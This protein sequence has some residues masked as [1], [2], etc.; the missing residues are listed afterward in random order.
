MS[1]NTWSWF[2]PFWW[3]SG[4]T[5]KGLP[6]RTSAPRYVTVCVLM[7]VSICVPVCMCV[8]AWEWIYVWLC[9]SACLYTCEHIWRSEVNLEFH[10]SG[11]VHFVFWDEVTNWS[12]P[13]R[14]GGSASESQWHI[15]LHLPNAGI[16]NVYHQAPLFFAWFWG[17]KCPA[18]CLHG[19]TTFLTLSNA[20]STQFKLLFPCCQLDRI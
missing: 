12:L 5:H 3:S 9:I 2:S 20:K 6:S 10:S 4:H 17:V 11:V 7:C 14:L 15:C 16:P 13:I 1:Q 19:H 8:C 18:S